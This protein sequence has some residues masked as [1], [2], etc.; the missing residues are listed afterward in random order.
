MDERL[1]TERV[2]LVRLSGAAEPSNSNFCGRVEHVRTG[3]V[4]KF[5]SM[6]EVEEFIGEM[7][8]G[9]KEK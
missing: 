5:A 9:V 4:M 6:H 3:R 1:P 8:E 7:L 2:F